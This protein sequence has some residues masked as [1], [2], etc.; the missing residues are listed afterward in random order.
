VGTTRWWWVRHAPVPV[1]VHGGRIYGANDVPCD[2]SDAATFAG[3]ARVLPRDAVLVTSNLMRTTM[4]AEATRAAGLSL[5]EAIV[6]PA[7]AEQNFGDW[8]GMTYDEVYDELGARHAFWLAP[9]HNTPPGGESFADLVER[10]RDGIVRLTREHRGRDIAAFAHGGSIRAAIGVALAIDPEQ[11]LG[12]DIHNCS[13]TRLVHHDGSD[14]DPRD[15][16]GVGGI[17]QPPKLPDG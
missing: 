3:L 12:F 11:A 2:T 10:V 17:N 14:D 1:S 16:W 9:A 7:F 6:E 13:V 15:H 4:T 5:P 8:T